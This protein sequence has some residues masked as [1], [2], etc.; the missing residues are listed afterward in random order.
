MDGQ[1][2]D[3]TIALLRLL[4]FLF[5]VL[6]SVIAAQLYLFARSTALGRVWRPFL[7]GAMLLAAWSLAQF[8]NTFFDSL[9][10]RGQ[11]A[12]MVMDLLVLLAVMHLAMGFYEMRQAYFRPDSRRQEVGVD[13]YDE[14]GRPIVPAEPKP[15]PADDA[16]A[17]EQ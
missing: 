10:G 2:P 7:V 4:T 11:H 16:G 8:A 17:E 12:A 1:A 3:S 15:E 5:A 14:Y 6:G 9:F 13:D